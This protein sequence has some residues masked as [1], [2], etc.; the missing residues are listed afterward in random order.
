MQIKTAAQAALLIEMLFDAVEHASLEYERISRETPDATDAEIE[1][2]EASIH[3]KAALRNEIVPIIQRELIDL[4]T[5]EAVLAVLRP[6]VHLSRDE[7]AARLSQKNF[8]VDAE[9]IR[10]SL[11]RLVAGNKVKISIMSSVP[12]YYKVS[13]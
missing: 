9:K 7:V 5:D 4:M 12:R 3:A 1:A 11:M 8:E 2:A 10:E 13:L 6:H